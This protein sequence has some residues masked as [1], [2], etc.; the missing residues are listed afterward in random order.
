LFLGYENIRTK[1]VELNVQEMTPKS[2]TKGILANALSPHPYLFWFSV[3]GPIYTKA[4]GQETMAALAFVLVFYV[5]LV[6]SKVLLAVI[7]GKSK[8]FLSGKVYLGVMRSLGVVLCV[9]GLFLFYDGIQL[10]K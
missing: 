2:L 8:S 10:L 5:F 6:G 9:L 7:T 1:P 3:G 4:M